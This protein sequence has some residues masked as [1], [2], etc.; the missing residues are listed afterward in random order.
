MRKRVLAVIVFVLLGGALL[1]FLPNDRY[2]VYRNVSYG[3]H[4]E[5]NT[6]DIYLPE[7]A[8]D[9]DKPAHVFM[10]VHGGGWTSGSNRDG[11]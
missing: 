4:G 7:K 3:Q 9:M 11:E 6:M 1:M 8:D 10:Y 5:R 2:D